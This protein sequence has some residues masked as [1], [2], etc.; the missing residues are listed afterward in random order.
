MFSPLRRL[1]TRFRHG[2]TAIFACFLDE[3]TPA[4]ERLLRALL[5]TAEGPA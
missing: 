5:A 3:L 1:L 4:D 2:Q